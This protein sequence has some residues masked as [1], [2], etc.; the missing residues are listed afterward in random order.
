MKIDKE[1]LAT[2]LGIIFIIIV[3]AGLIAWDSIWKFNLC[4]PDASDSFLYC[5]QYAI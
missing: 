5:F 2:I 1:L 3:V 4:Y